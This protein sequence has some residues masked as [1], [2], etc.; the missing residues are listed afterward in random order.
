MADLARVSEHF[1]THAASYIGLTAVIGTVLAGHLQ[2]VSLL[3]TGRMQAES[4][5]EA[6]RNRVDGQLESDRLREQATRYGELVQASTRIR[7]L[8]QRFEKMDAKSKRDPAIVGELTKGTDDL[9]A[10]ANSA[11]VIL[12]SHKSKAVRE[13]SHGIAFTPAVRRPV[14]GNRDGRQPERL[15]RRIPGQGPHRL[16]GPAAVAGATRKPVGTGAARLL[17]AAPDTP[18]HAYRC[19]SR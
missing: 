11:S 14:P 7:I 1:R 12:Q 19:V 13:N 5:V 15:P 8:M 16:R 6:S 9:A 2:A 18:R 10:R 4:T 17:V 3:E